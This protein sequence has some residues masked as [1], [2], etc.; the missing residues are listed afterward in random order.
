MDGDHLILREDLYAKQ[1][2][3]ERIAERETFSE[4]QQ[5]LIDNWASWND[6]KLEQLNADGFQ[7]AKKNQR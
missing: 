4:Q 5:F 1:L 3:G 6:F 2:T 7:G